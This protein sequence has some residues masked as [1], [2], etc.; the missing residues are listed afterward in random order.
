MDDSAL[1]VDQLDALSRAVPDDTERKDI[2]LYLK[3]AILPQLCPLL[4]CP[5]VAP[6]CSSAHAA[7]PEGG[8]SLPLRLL[9]HR[10]I[11]LPVVG[12][13]PLAAI[14]GASR[15]SP[16]AFCHAGPNAVGLCRSQQD[17]PS[18]VLSCWSKCCVLH[19]LSI[20][21]TNSIGVCFPIRGLPAPRPHC[22]AS[23]PASQVHYLTT[24]GPPG[25]DYACRGGTS[26]QPDVHAWCTA[27]ALGTWSCSSPAVVPLSM[28]QHGLAL[29]TTG[30]SIGSLPFCRGSTPS[31]AT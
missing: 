28:L 14:A 27:A 9:Q 10:L 2:R 26:R 20:C 30:L 13:P 25:H 8:V 6:A 21:P 15:T 17:L 19:M 31:T 5:K 23:A 22:K 24:S 1:T 4:L 11:L 7:A 3:V 16:A 12:M 18:S 29:Y